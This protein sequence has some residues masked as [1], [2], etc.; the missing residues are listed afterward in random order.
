[1][2]PKRRPAAPKR[3]KFSS[4]RAAARANSPPHSKPNPGRGTRHD[5]R[6]C[7]HAHRTD[8]RAKTPEST[9][10]SPAEKPHNPPPHT[11][12]CVWPQPIHG[13]LS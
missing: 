7:E 12:T 9:C 1:M 13:G 4:A 5:E 2:P 6:T 8:A 3:P 10:R 11:C